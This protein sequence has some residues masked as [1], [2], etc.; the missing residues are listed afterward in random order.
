MDNHS[1]LI[2]DDHK[3]VREG[4]HTL[5]EKLPGFKVIG[6]ACNGTEAVELVSELQ[7]HC[8]IMDISMPI[9]NGLEASRQILQT[10]PH[11]RIIALSMHADRRFVIEALKIGIKGYLLKDSAFEELHAAIKTVMNNQIYLSSTITDLVVRELVQHSPHSA[12]PSAFA[13]LSPREREILQLF[14]EGQSTKEI[15][16]HL[17]LSVKTVETHRKQV[18]DK[19]NIH[20]IA[21]LTKYAI[22]EG[23]TSL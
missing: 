17:N 1:I 13:V 16:S 2:V 4:L 12:I 14:A 19:L 22:R 3:I 6:E 7:P 20:S 10:F 9:M 23:L 18:M 8:I 21:E 15:A 11:Q 5:L